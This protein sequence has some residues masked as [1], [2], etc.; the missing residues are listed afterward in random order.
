MLKADYNYL[1]KLDT[2][3]KKDAALIIS[4]LDPD[5]Y[6]HIRFTFKY[7]DFEK[8]PE[9][10]QAYKLY[11][12]F[13]SIDFYRHRE[14]QSHPVAYVVECK[15][16]DWPVPDELFNLARERYAKEAVDRS[17]DNS[18]GQSAGEAS[19][20][21]KDF[22]LKTLGVLV[23]LYV[24]QQKKPRLGD[25]KNVNVS[26][27]VEDILQFIDACNVEKVYG[28]GKSSLN[29]RIADGLRLIGT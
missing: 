27:V 23:K 16:K 26:R 28:L 2:W 11:K 8:N 22:L 12:L 10:I 13:L 17:P 21:E 20:K 7:L 6:R 5:Q 9:L 25:S 4:G 15:K 24:T 29:R 14:Y 18:D 3:S 1:I 19:Q